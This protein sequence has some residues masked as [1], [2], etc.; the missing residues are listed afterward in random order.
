MEKEERVI[1][2]GRVDFRDWRQLFGLKERDR[3]MHVYVIGQTGTGKSTLLENLMRQDLEAGRGFAFL[4]P[5]GDTVDALIGD[6]PEESRRRL[7]YLDVPDPA[8]P[9]GFNP[10]ESVPPDQRA[11]AA[12]G[13]VEAFKNVWGQ[14]WGPRLEHIFRN[15]LLTLLDQPQATLADLPRLFA[16][17]RYRREA[18]SR[19]IHTAVRDFWLQEFE[20]YPIRYRAEM[21]GPLRNKL[22]AFLAQPDLFRILSRSRSTFNLR[23]I[24]DSGKVLL[25]NLAKG[26]MGADACSLLGALLV[27]RIGLSALSR[28]D[29]PEPQRRN[30]FLYLDEFHSFT[31]LAVATF[32]SELRKYHLGLV[33]AHQYVDQLDS[34]VRDA[35]FGNVGTL[36]AFRVG[37]VDARFIE[38]YFSPEFEEVD[39][40]YLPN[41]HAYVRLMVD[42]T[43]T[44]PF[45]AE[46]LPSPRRRV[47]G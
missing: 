21:L 11:L 46:T 41:Y 44:R 42:G 33:L 10:L 30:F 8:A 6:V 18:V 3:L 16:D 15:A 29:L 2:I 22:G 17:D 5:H 40:M 4:D 45:S 47:D 36:V 25:V 34:E 27:T 31:T 37:P 14:W 1:I 28:A 43:V 24:M 35:V 32:L 12:S 39:L 19:V 13:I 38:K 26:K 20:K 7:A 9:V 23:E